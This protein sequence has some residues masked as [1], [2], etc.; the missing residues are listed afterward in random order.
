MW[1]KPTIELR[2]GEKAGGSMVM[3]ER[4]NSPMRSPGRGRLGRGGSA[5]L[6]GEMSPKGRLATTDFGLPTVMEQQE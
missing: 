5:N 4:S 6:N 2:T 1:T 3:S